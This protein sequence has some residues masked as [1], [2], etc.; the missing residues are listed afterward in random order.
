MTEVVTE[1]GTVTGVATAEMQGVVLIL[2]VLIF[3][4]EH[5][6]CFFYDVLSLISSMQPRI[7]QQ[8]FA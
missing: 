6:K 5:R 8:A 1:A 4:L 2:N 7:L 3:I